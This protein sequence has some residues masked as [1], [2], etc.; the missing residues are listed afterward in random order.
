MRNV[1]ILKENQKI[2]LF[3]GNGTEANGVLVSVSPKQALVQIDSFKTF[4]QK[5]P[6]ITLACAIPKK[7]KFELIIEKAT[8]LGVNE[9]IPLVTKRTEV[10]FTESRRNN[11]QS[12]FQ[13]VAISAAKQSQLT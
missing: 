8:E 6:S 2:Q 11:K 4:S 5:G 3:D 7:S 9:I 1:L 10:N 13:S 12:R